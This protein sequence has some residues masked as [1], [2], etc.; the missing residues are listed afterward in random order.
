MFL[1]PLIDRLRAVHTVTDL[2]TPAGSCCH[3][4][5]K[6]RA[7]G[8]TVLT[9]DSGAPCALFPSDAYPKF[10]RSLFTYAPLRLRHLKPVE[11]R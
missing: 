11:S 7:T 4:G 9:G 10:R 2:K 6:S 8:Q 3:V 5:L 1:F